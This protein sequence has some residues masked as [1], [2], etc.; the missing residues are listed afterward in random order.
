MRK[1]VPWM[2]V[3]L[4]ILHQDNWLWEDTTLD[5]G[6]MPRAL[7][8]HAGISLAAGFTWFLAVKF[9]WP[10]GLDAAEASSEGTTQA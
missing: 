2:I 9:C 10:A 6:F 4:L 8:F 7:L 5:F 3:A 1:I